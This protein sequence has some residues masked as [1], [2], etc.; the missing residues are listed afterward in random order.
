MLTTHQ[1]EAAELVKIVPAKKQA[2][3]TGW[4]SGQTCLAASLL[5]AS[6]GAS[7]MAGGSALPPSP[8]S[9]PPAKP[10][11]A[12][13]AGSAYDKLSAQPLGALAKLHNDRGRLNK[14]LEV[15]QKLF[16]FVPPG[17]GGA[18]AAKWALALFQGMYAIRIDPPEE[19]ALEKNIPKAFVPQLKLC[20]PAPTG[21]VTVAG[22]TGAALGL[23]EFL[24]WRVKSQSPVLSSVFIVVGTLF[25]T[26]IRALCPHEV[27]KVT[28]SDS[29]CSDGCCPDG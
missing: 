19:N 28:C 25:V 14:G 27:A 26:A 7:G 23:T 9:T 6:T 17:P 22:P 18:G 2:G 4:Q 5:P 21:T 13:S 8:R 16:P 10:L 11:P 3:F 20:A 29:C 15:L 24:H 12:S 1:L